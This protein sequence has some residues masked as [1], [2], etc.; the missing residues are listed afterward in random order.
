[1]KRWAL[2]AFALLLA[3]LLTGAALAE[4]PVILQVQG[5]AGE[6]AAHNHLK[7]KIK[8]GKVETAFLG[9]EE[10]VV[11]D[12][13]LVVSKY[14]GTL[15]NKDKSIKAGDYFVVSVDK[16]LRL[17]GIIERTKAI[18][19]VL[20]WQKP[21]GSAAVLGRGYWDEDKHQVVYLITEDIS[22][23][24]EV[25]FY[26]Y[27][28][29]MVDGKVQ[30]VNGAHTFTNTYGNTVDKIDSRVQFSGTSTGIQN[31]LGG[32]TFTHQ[33]Y[34]TVDTVDVQLKRYVRYLHYK[35]ADV[36]AAA[37]AEGKV[38]LGFD[39]GTPQTPVRAGNKVRVYLAPAAV[40]DSLYLD[41]A[42]LKDVTDQFT[43]AYEGDTARFRSKLSLTQ[44]LYIVEENSYLSN[45]ADFRASM[46]MRFL[47]ANGQVLPQATVDATS[48]LSRPDFQGLMQLQYVAG[49][50]QFPVKV[51][52][53]LKKDHGTG[54][55]LRGAVF[56]LSEVGPDGKERVLQTVTTSAAGKA[57]FAPVRLGTYWIRETKAPDGYH[58]DADP[59]KNKMELNLF[60]LD[61]EHLMTTIYNIKNSE[62][63]PTPKATVKP[64]PKTTAKPVPKTG[65]AGI[66]PFVPLMLVSA[67][68][69]AGLT[70]KKKRMNKTV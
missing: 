20:L 37:A 29:Y 66:S 14:S 17:N 32:S 57:S 21:D 62:V 53:I 9:G 13:R 50:V 46:I 8:A 61:G 67:A 51:I 45:E 24:E 22:G 1:M 64:A 23:A 6:L 12:T 65:D 63:T 44:P 30:P 11:G 54:A 56:E 31:T 68:A 4:N 26:V 70:A 43:V 7:D 42:A 2:R 16:A 39:I 41:P 59:N 47:D 48:T 40:P 33:V 28:V 69:L 38:F 35:L 3:L 36:S 10:G 34:F 27:F 18:P 15:D 25:N 5:Q 58:L 55:A 52:S 60:E 49:D 19:Y